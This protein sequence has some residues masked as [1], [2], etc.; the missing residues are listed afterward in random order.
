VCGCH[1]WADIEGWLL[2]QHDFWSS[3]SAAIAIRS[4]CHTKIQATRPALLVI[5]CE[6]I[7]PIKLKAKLGRTKC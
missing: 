5:G 4:T 3:S 6:T 1:N 2:D 7:L